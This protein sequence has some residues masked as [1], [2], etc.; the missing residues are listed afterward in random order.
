MGEREERYLYISYVN[1]VQQWRQNTGKDVSASFYIPFLLICTQDQRISAN[2]A[3]AEVDVAA[4]IVE[5][6]TT[7]AKTN[8]PSP[9]KKAHKIKV[10]I[11]SS[12]RYKLRKS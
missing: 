12:G 5:I 9:A 1:Y 4:D 7:T 8:P 6:L 10:N 2:G 11:S 3:C